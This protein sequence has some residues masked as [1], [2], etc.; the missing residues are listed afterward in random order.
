VSAAAVLIVIV[1]AL[2]G[3]VATIAWCEH[4]DQTT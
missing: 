4:A 1:T 2:A 3:L